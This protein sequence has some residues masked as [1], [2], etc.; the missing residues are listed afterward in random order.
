MRYQPET[1]PPI[2]SSPIHYI[3]PLLSSSDLLLTLVFSFIFDA[4]YVRR[5]A[6]AIPLISLWQKQSCFI[7]YITAMD[8]KLAG[9]A[10]KIS[11]YV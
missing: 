9:S 1:I 6:K 5:G 3:S 4:C 10:S 2:S 8:E 7:K 11:N